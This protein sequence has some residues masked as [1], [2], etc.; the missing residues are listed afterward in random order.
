MDLT[1]IDTSELLEEASRRG[2]MHSERKVLVNRHYEFPRKLKPFKIG[3]VSDTHL[4]SQMQ[5]KT[6]LG[7]A[8][9]IFKQ[10]GIETVI[11]AGD[12]VEGSGKQYKGQLYEMFLHGADSMLDY[13]VE[14]YPCVPGI[15]TYVIGGSHD[16]SYFKDG[17]YDILKKLAEKRKDI[18]Y[19]GNAGAFLNFGK[20]RIY[21]MHPSGGVPYARSYRLQKIISEFKDKEKPNIIIS[22]HLHITCELPTYRNVAG[23]QLPCFQ[24]QTQY[25]REKGLSPDIGFL[26]LEIFPDAKGLSHFKT[27]WHIFYAPVEGDY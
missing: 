8:Y 11:H 10:E 23:F 27:D 26:I 25:L 14:V 12:L 22:G 2:F 4:G 7:E 9:R 17:G 16:Y 5:Q 13:A 19:L 24:L 1:K 6:L 18:K 21:V 15:T 20:I 3:I